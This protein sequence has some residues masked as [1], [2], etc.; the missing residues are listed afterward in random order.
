MRYRQS[1]IRECIDMLIAIPN[2]LVPCDYA[3][4]ESTI[5]DSVKLDSADYVIDKAIKL[6]RK[7]VLE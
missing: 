3:G 7:E 2:S 4:T 6:L 1:E 5:I